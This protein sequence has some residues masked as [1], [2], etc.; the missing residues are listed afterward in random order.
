LIGNVIGSEYKKRFV[1]FTRALEWNLEHHAR[2]KDLLGEDIKNILRKTHGDQISGIYH[3][4]LTDFLDLKLGI[5]K[6]KC[7]KYNAKQ[8]EQKLRV[9]LMD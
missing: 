9:G 3:K 2:Y 5:D 8:V 1:G 6:A 7:Y 4:Y